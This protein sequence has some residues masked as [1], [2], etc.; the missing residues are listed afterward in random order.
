MNREDRCQQPTSN[1]LVIPP[2]AP[3]DMM[4]LSAVAKKRGYETIF[5][6]YALK[7]ETIYDFL[8]DLRVEKPDFIVI[9]IASTTL[10]SD[11]SILTQAQD[12]LDDIVVI[13][14]GA[15]FNFNSY[16][17]LQK[18]PQIDIALR[19]EIEPAFDEI[20]QYKDFKSIKGITYQ[21]NNK[22]V[23]NP[24]RE[25]SDD[26]DYLPFLDRDLIN[27]NIYV[28]PDTK[29]PQTI[30]RVSKGCPNHCFF[31]L[32]TPLN[33]SF[34]R[35]RDPQLIVDEI[36]ECVNTY[37]IRDFIFWS[38]IFNRDNAWVQRL[39]RL[40]LEND[41]NINFCANTRAD[42]V[43]FE[44]LQLMKKA[45]CELVSIGIESGN[46]EILNKM[47]K[48]VTLAQI[49]NAVSMIEKAKLQV[50]AYYVIGLP[51]ETQKTIE[52]TFAFAK[53]L[54]THY[55]TFYTATAL[56][57]S[58]FY[59]YVNK[60]RLG[61]VNYESP[62]VFPSINSYALTSQQIYDYNN[63]FNKEYY[64]RPKYFLKIAKQVNSVV[65]FKSYFDA[66]IKLM[67]KH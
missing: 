25:L 8:R 27:N 5:K 15:I 32:A 62:Y 55:A 35:Y 4:S 20:I 14:K 54:N 41:L 9:N 23:S 46:Q 58:K 66:F 65:K 31:C 48:K 28:R 52:E 33:G 12:M 30:I 17:L 40:I 47:G 37:G 13:V 24:D 34:V 10:E 57:G 39:C 50:Y 51:W 63:K 7:N 18:Y 26:L 11:L 53:K 1:T 59:D 2:L 36:K 21:I 19:G 49:E 43:N 42:T 16:A 61:T 56:M 3:V 60:N 45:G 29:K 38:D 44:T 64:L 6:D 67:K 22:I